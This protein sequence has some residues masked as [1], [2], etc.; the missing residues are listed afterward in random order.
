MTTENDRYVQ[1]QYCRLGKVLFC[2]E[3]KVLISGFDKKPHMVL[4]DMA[5]MKRIR[6]RIAEDQAAKERA[7][8]SQG[9]DAGKSTS[10]EYRKI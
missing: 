2:Y 8:L 3:D 10:T 6:D 5:A 9:Q 4:A 1:G 7:A